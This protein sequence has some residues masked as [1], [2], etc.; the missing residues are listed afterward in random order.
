MRARLPLA[1]ALVL[2]LSACEPAPPSEPVEP[3]Q[4]SVTA[5]AAE[6]DPLPEGAEQFYDQTIDWANCANPDQGGFQCGSVTVPLDWEDTG[7]RQIT[8]ALIRQTPEPDDRGTIWMN[9]GG[10]G[11]SGINTLV[12]SGEYLVT[13]DLADEFTIA[14]FDPRGVNESAPVDC[15]PDVELDEYVAGSGVPETDAGMDALLEDGQAFAEAC[16]QNS[17]ALLPF[18]GTRD[19]ARDLDV[20]RA[21]SEAEQLD[22]LGFSYGTLLG[23]V[24]ADLFPTK[25]GR[26]VLDGGVDPNLSGEELALGQAR[27]FEQALS[28]F[29]EY[30]L[31]SQECPLDGSVDEAKTQMAQVLDRTDETPLPLW[32]GR[33]ANASVLSTGVIAGLYADDTWDY[34][35]VGLQALL[36]DNDPSTLVQLADSMDQRDPDG[37]QSNMLEA[38]TAINCL[39]YTFPSGA[40]AM[41]A[42]AGA[43]EEAAPTLGKYLGFGGAV[44]GQWPTAAQPLDG[45]VDPSGSAP[46]LVVGTRGDPATPYE[47]S[48]SL[49]TAM[50]SPLL[51]YEGEG[52]IAYPRGGSCIADSVDAFFTDGDLPADGTAC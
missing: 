44:C 38:N 45:D 32:D 31:G 46:V 15:L 11:G 40:E 18:L 41:R 7:G 42:E 2:G 19:T 9:P 10:P 8:L 51:T 24:Y 28:A 4:N 30:C 16:Q 5:P 13:P 29:V 17:G 27:G 22:Y 35:M 33:E 23:A 48:E 20:I 43:L 1:V 34:L 37:Y 50:S 25:V 3:P 49:S 6:D 21:A 47:W 12:S 14:S 36:D 52:H 26:F 39:D